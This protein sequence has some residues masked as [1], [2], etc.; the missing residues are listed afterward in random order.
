VSANAAQLSCQ[1]LVELVT[2][3]LEGTLDEGRVAALDAHLL[4]C[5][6]CDAY[7]E[8]M[9]QTVAALRGLGPVEPLSADTREALL[10]AFQAALR[11]G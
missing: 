3:Y 9:R 11:S 10:A 7:V 4:G 6:G 8:Q 1:E 2:D 5:G